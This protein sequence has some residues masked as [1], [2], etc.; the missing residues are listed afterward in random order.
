MR[1]LELGRGREGRE[2]TLKRAMQAMEA[3]QS[4]FSFSI[5]FF[6]SSSSFFSLNFRLSRIIEPS[7]LM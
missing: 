3:C 6:V 1:G 5:F 7:V 4:L 2:L